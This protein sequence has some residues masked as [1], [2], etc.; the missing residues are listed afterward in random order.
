MEAVAPEQIK[1]LVIDWHSL[2]QQYPGI[3]S[4][5]GCYGILAD[6]LDSTPN[7]DHESPAKPDKVGNRESPLS[8]SSGEDKYEHVTDVF[9]N[10]WISSALIFYHGHNPTMHHLEKVYGFRLAP[11]Y[12]PFHIRLTCR[13]CTRMKFNLGKEQIR[14]INDGCVHLRCTV[15]ANR[16]PQQARRALN[17]HSRRIVISIEVR[18]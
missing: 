7:A 17:T 3:A 13:G 10:N 1:T 14:T 11:K 6:I 18:T 12:V 4:F 9:I 2:R 8:V 15:L 5:Q 16:L